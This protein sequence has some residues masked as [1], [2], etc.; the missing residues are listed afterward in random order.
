MGKRRAPENTLRQFQA[1]PG[2]AL[3]EAMTFGMDGS[4]DRQ[5][6]KGQKSMAESDTLPVEMPAEA[7]RVLE[8]A[9]VKFGEPV[10]DD[11]L[12][13]Y[14]TLPTGWKK[15]PTEHSMWLTLVD[16]KG[17]ERASIFYKAAFYDRN[18][19]LSTC[20]RYGFQVDYERLKKDGVGV[21]NI[22]DCGTVIHTTEPISA[23]DRDSYEVS[24]EVD[25]LAEA[26]LDTTYPNWRDAGAY[27][28]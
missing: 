1:H 2:F 9:G 19:Q 10:K 6:A 12:F 27:W 17:R 20:R 25:Q 15:M 24:E 8:K 7:K 5:N 23:V 13:Q 16:G 21:A 18:T 11:E 14:V 4:I 22:T 26:W 3:A 28:D